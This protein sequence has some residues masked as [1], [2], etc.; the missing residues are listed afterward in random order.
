V[1]SDSRLFVA[2]LAGLLVGAAASYAMH[3]QQVKP[4]PVYLI[5]EADAITDSAAL[6]EYGGKVGATLAPFQGHYRFAVRGGKIESLEGQAPVGMVVIQFDS[7]QQAH[8]WYDSAAYQAIR[9]IRQA[10]SKGR[11]FIVEGAP[12]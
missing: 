10:N 11:M 9:P 2:A 12:Q 4:S 1:K 3:G 7:S 5:S 8:A 6:R